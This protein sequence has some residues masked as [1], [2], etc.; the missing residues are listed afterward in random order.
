[1]AEEPQQKPFKDYFSPSP[2]LNISCIWFLDVAA[3]SYEIKPNILN[4]L[5]SFYNLDNKDPYNHLNNFYAVCQA[6]DYEDFL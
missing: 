5:P 3:R 6:F 1:M 4:C 2:N